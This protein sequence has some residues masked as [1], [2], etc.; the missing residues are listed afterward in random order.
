MTRRNSVF[1]KRKYVGVQK[2]KPESDQQVD[3]TVVLGLTP[4]RDDLPSVS[5]S[6]MKID[7]RELSYSEYEAEKIYELVDIESLMS[8]FLE[9]SACRFCGAKPTNYNNGTRS[10]PEKLS[11][12]PGLRSEPACAGNGQELTPSI[13]QAL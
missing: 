6:K 10:G 11:R 8:K 4:K 3:S 2:H 7:D 1:K 12:N 9:I 13:W 5:P